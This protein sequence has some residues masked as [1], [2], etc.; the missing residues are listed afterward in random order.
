MTILAC[1]PPVLTMMHASTFVFSDVMYR[2]LRAIA[3]LSLCDITVSK[4][5]LL[6]RQS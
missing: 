4:L 3:L 5:V 2:P 1:V 6:E